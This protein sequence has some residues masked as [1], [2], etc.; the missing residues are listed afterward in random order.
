MKSYNILL[1]AIEE[2]IAILKGWQEALLKE[3][4]PSME[5]EGLILHLIEAETTAEVVYLAEE[6]RKDIQFHQKRS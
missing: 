1:C 5:L 4:K 2:G 3:K 6:Q